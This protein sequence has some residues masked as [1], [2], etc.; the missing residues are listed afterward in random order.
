MLGVLGSDLGVDLCTV[1]IVVA[2]GRIDFCY[3]QIGIQVQNV[4]RCIALLVDRSKYSDRGARASDAGRSAL[5]PGS[6][7]DVSRRLDGQ[8]ADDLVNGPLSD[9]C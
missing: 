5:N 4:F 2:Q 3:T 1:F 6:Q 8:I 7:Q 9:L